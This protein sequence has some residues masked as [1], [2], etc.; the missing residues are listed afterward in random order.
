[1]KIIC[2]NDLLVPR[3]ATPGSAG[4]DLC[5]AG[6]RYILYPS[7]C[8]IF[9]TGVRLD[10]RDDH[11]V[12]LIFPRS[13]L[14]IK[15]LTLRNGTG[16]IDSDYQ[17][18]IKVCLWYTGQDFMIIE[19]GMRIAQLVFLPIHRVEFE[20]VESFEPTERGENGIGSTG[21]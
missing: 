13:G 6:D 21:Q 12:G 7:E 16:V 15:G 9:N 5:N 11:L 19:Y 2:S 20:R 4:V 14:G 3:Y 1:M 18:E 17:G 8:K 10:M